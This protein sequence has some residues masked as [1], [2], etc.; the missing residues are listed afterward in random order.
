[1]T[2]NVVGE[3]SVTI[4]AEWNDLDEKIQRRLVA[5]ARKAGADAEKELQR[6]GSRAGQK[7]GEQFSRDANGRLRDARGKFVT[8]GEAAA[9]GFGQGFGEQFTRD[10]NGRLRDARGRFVTEGEA[11]GTGFGAGL[12]KIMGR[13]SKK[14]GTESGNFFS[15]AFRSAAARGLGTALFKGLAVSAAGIVTALSPL[16][17]LLGGAAAAIVALAAAIGQASGAALSLGGILGALGLGVAAAKVGFSGLGDAVKAQSAAFQE[18]IQTGAVSTATQEK[19]DEAL[20]SLSP[21][22]RAVV[23]ALGSM[24]QAWRGVQQSVQEQLFRN[25]GAVLQQLGSRYLPI[26]RTQLSTAAATLNRTAVGLGQFLASGARS[27]QINSIFTGLNGI[28]ATLLS[29]VQPLTG[30]FLDVFQASLPFAQQLADSIARISRQFAAFLT[31]AVASGSFTEF[32]RGAMEAAR[33]LLQLLVNLGRIIGTVFAAGAESGGNLLSI[34]TNLTGQLADFLSSAAGQEALASF[35]GLI[36]DAGQILVG[37]FTTLRPLLAGIGALFDAL[38]PALATLGAALTPVIAALAQGLGTAL[39][40]LAPAIASLVTA[41]APLIATVGTLLVGAINLLAPILT[42]LITGFAQIVPLLAPIVQLLGTALLGAIS[43]LV[44]LFAQLVPVVVQF[45][46]AFA[47]GLTPV[48][49]ALAPL[50]PQ[51]VAALVQVLGAFL[52]LLPALLPLL[53]PLAQVSLELANL[54]VAFA[55]LLP[56]VAQFVSQILTNLAPALVFIVGQVAGVISSFANLVAVFARV[57]GA[58]VN[59]VAGFIANMNSLRSQGSSIIGAFVGTFLGYFTRL[60]G[61]VLGAISGMVSRALG[62][63]RSFASS[64]A[65][66]ASSVASGII[67]AIRSGLSGLAG[68]FRAPFDAARSAVAGAVEGIVGVVSG[69]VD[70]IQGLVSRISGAIGKIRNV[71]LPNI[72]IPGFA[73]GG[74]IDRPTVLAAGEGGKR[75]VIIPLTRPQ[76]AQQLMRATGLDKMADSGRAASSKTQT[77]NVPIQA[78]T[79]VDQ[80]ALVER[81]REILVSFGFRPQLGLDTAGGTI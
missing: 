6:S 62:A 28:L 61:Q 24:Q 22:A 8:E 69:A 4:D 49:A 51:I 66:A 7:F 40:N 60:G 29:T 70:R 10:I 71:G 77:F 31:E 9:R 44:P 45:V 2:S 52:Q 25:V 80:N 1:M 33:T 30:A 47:A 20:K 67:S 55:P 17:T 41:F 27:S 81:M 18:L 36:G 57:V 3:A 78:G 58:I 63:L 50:L 48:L 42:T 38:R 73:N 11:A 15:N 19:L 75:E 5:A 21:S 64:A 32:M 76:R 43:Q 14:S 53:P 65:S 16:S 34:L 46:T 39:T 59:F 37:I 72:D 79:V 23:T 35:F 54:L 13:E 74:I 26:L 12:R 68:A 56:V